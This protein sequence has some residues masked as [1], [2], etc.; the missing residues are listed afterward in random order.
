MSNKVFAVPIFLVV[1]R[2]TLETVIIVSVLLAFLK[3]TLDALRRQVWVGMLSGFL[4]CLIVAAALIGTFYGIGQNKWEANEY[5][6]EGAFSL[7]AALIITVMGV[8]LL[9]IGQMQEKW[10]VKLAQAI[11]APLKDSKGPRAWF[12]RAMEKYSMFLL[13]FVT[14]LREG[15]EAILFVSAVSFSAPATAIPLPAVLGLAVGGLVGYLIYKG[16]ATARLQVFLVVSTCFL[17]IVAAGLFSRGVW[18]IQQ[19]QWNKIVGGDSAE[20]GMGPGSY[21]IDQSVWHVN[22]CSPE[23]NGGGGWGILN[24]IFGWTNSATYGSVISYNVYWIVVISGFL[25]LR[26]R[27]AKGRGPFA[28]IGKRSSDAS[29]ADS[30]AVTESN[31]GIPDKTA[32]TTESGEVRRPST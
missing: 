23:Y 26:Y 27:E 9:R 18:Y 22:C 16:G 28:S 14:I 21:D 10:R 15:I 20:L 6:V 17:Y 19:Q 1:F 3:Q 25:F 13:P 24:A 4:I 2:E 31:V 32:T 30:P 5:Y 29:D 8:A 7:F 12:G 11:E